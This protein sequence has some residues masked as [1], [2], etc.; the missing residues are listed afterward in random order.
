MHPA[1]LE[2]LALRYQALILARRC[3]Q[4]KTAE[5]FQSVDIDSLE[6]VRPR[7]VGIEQLALHAVKQVGLR[8]KLVELG[9]NCHQLSVALGNIIA[10]ID[11]GKGREQ[12]RKL[13]SYGLP[14]E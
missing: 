10:Y 8:D 11:V 3:E 2:T 4:E 7:R 13:C 1:E 12:E 6:L 5:D 14:R 9:F